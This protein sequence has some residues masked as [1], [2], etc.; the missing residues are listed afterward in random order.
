MNWTYGQEHSPFDVEYG[1]LSDD[2]EFEDL[3]FSI[4]KLT[5]QRPLAEFSLEE[6]GACFQD[7]CNISVEEQCEHLLPYRDLDDYEEKERYVRKFYDLLE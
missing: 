2:E 3:E 7:F 6:H 5:V 1:P 4:Q